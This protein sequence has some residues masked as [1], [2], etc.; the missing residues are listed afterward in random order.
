MTTLEAQELVEV[1]SRARELAINHRTAIENGD[2]KVKDA[3][4]AIAALQDVVNALF[5]AEAAAEN[6][7]NIFNNIGEDPVTETPE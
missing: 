1:I 6:Y 2:V 7:D 4:G 3:K 5:N